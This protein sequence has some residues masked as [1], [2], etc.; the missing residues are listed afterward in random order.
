MIAPI[1]NEAYWTLDGIEIGMY[2]GLKREVIERLEPIDTSLA[3]IPVFIDR[4]M[5]KGT[6]E[7]WQHGRRIAVIEGISA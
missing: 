1:P 5:P 3:G 2:K 7:L 4:T 6:L